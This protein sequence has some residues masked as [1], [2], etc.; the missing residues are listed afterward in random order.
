MV[1]SPELLSCL[2]G[3]LPLGRSQIKTEISPKGRKVFGQ[4][5]GFVG[6][7]RPFGRSDLRH[8]HRPG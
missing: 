7:R 1:D 5:P 6:G 8:E 2:K 3:G 4:I